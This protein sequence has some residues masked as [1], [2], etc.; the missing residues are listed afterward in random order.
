MKVTPIAS[1]SL[2]VR[3][4]ATLVETRDLRIAI[5]PDA[6]LGPSR[7]GLPPHE[8]ELDALS[9]A[10]A[11]IY[12]RAAKSDDLVIS[13]YHFDHFDIGGSHFRGKTV[14][15]KSIT[16]K[17][18]KSQTERGAAFK[19][20]VDG[21]VKEL[22]YADGKEFNIGETQL[23]FSPPAPHGPEGI[24][25]GYVIMTLVDDGSKAK[26]AGI[27]SGGSFGRFV[28]ASDVQGPVAASTA[29]WI[30]AQKP[31]LIYMDGPPILFLGWKFSYKNLE[32]AKD[33]F[34]R[35]LDETDARVI[36]DHHLLRSLDY[37][38]KFPFFDGERVV[39]AAEFLGRENIMLE[40][41]RKE[42]WKG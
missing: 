28:F 19:K 26:R 6:A 9:D 27:G 5:D 8:K 4:M 39:T 37:V 34:R 42:L 25:L 24:V 15:A 17:I 21:V 29:D 38:K 41:H 30:I 31:D 32:A 14:Y 10:K 12:A 16:S 33:N 11:D 35:I 40:A 18:N 22:I 23:R 20:A 7:Y 13:H 36:L 3:S 1:D 2:G